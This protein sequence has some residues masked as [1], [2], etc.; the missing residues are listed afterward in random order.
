VSRS[1]SSNRF[2]ALARQAKGILGVN[3][4]R[5]N[6]LAVGGFVPFEVHLDGR[7]LSRREQLQVE[8]NAWDARWAGHRARLIA[9]KG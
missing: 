7:R 2:L 4:T 5:P 9:S 3:D 1:I 6:Q 8:A